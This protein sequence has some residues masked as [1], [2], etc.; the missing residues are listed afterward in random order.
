MSCFFHAFCVV[1]RSGKV[2]QSVMLSSVGPQAIE[3]EGGLKSAHS[4]IIPYFNLIYSIQIVLLFVE[5]KRCRS[6]LPS[7]VCKDFISH[8]LVRLGKAT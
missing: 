6:K 4:K 3:N 8:G 5:G 2:A 7:P 1:C